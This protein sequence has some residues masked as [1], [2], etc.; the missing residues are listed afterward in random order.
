METF[1]ESLVVSTSKRNAFSAAFPAED[2]L[3]EV[4]FGLTAV[5]VIYC[6]SDNKDDVQARERLRKRNG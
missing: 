4:F 1:I 5:V 3:A 6:V 2:F